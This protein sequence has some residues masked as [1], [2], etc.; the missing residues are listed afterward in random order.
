MLQPFISHQFKSPVWRLEID[1]LN[2]L[3]LVEVR[4]VA[5]KQVSFSSINLDTG[6][7]YFDGLQTE[8]RWLTGIEAA[9]DGVLLLHHYQ[10]TDGPVHKGIIALDALTGKTIWSD[11]NSTFD[12]LTTNGPVMYDSR[13]QPRKLLL[14]DI[15]NGATIRPY[16][17]SIDLEL[18]NNIILP[19]AASDEFSL[20]LHLPVSP[21]ENTSHY[22][23][24]NNLRIVSLHALTAGTL[25]QHLY[26][27]DSENIVFEDLLN[28]DIQKLQPESF[29][30]CKDKLIYLKN[31]S[32]L[33]VLNL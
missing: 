32:Q 30:L 14:I 2:A 7:T 12:H 31:Q 6:E 33:K 18:T 8:E 20:S 5:N 26:M 23:E 25:Q 4:D 17:A 27:M 3:L 28:T 15:K 11:Y 24:H 22:V 29:L 19:D 21:L 10:S 9:F 16:E 13:M 1:G